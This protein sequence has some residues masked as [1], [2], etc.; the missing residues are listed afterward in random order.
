MTTTPAKTSKTSSTSST[1]QQGSGGL[2]EYLAAMDAAGAPVL[3]HLVLYSI[4]DGNVTRD[5]LE[6]WFAELDLDPKYIPPPLRAIDAFERV[7]GPDGSRMVGALDGQPLRMR[8]QRGKDAP[9]RRQATLMVRHVTRN[10]D[11]IVRHIVREVRDERQTKL[12]YVAKL[13]EC[14]FHRDK[15]TGT[16]S[17]AG[18]GRLEI[19]VDHAAIHQLPIAEQ[20]QAAAMVAELVEDLQTKYEHRRRYMTGDRIRGMLRNYIEDLNA[21]RVRPTGGVYFV[22]REHTET[23]GA[24]RELVTRCS[25]D[26]HLVRVPVPDHDEMREMVVDAWRSKTTEELQKLTRDIADAQH[27]A[28]QSGNPVTAAAAQVLYRRFQQLK[29]A[30]DEHSTQL[31]ASLDEED[32]ALQLLNLQIAGL[33]TQA[34]D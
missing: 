17:V 25:E 14:V 31:A 32:S 4:F 33:L 10:N 11:E 29:A 30:T 6:R 34:T 13:G 28:R 18:A 15:D 20:E 1:G 24:L 16:D 7:T 2:E 9:Q 5:D 3:G 22:Y 12:S 21:I 8:R 27:A 26:S 19:S 23:L